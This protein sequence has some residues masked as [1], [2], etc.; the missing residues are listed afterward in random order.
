MTILW[1]FGSF[2]PVVVSCTKEIWQP[3]A[4]AFL[5]VVCIGGHWLEKAKKRFSR[6]SSWN[7]N[8]LHSA[9]EFKI[10]AS[11]WH[12]CHTCHTCLRRDQTTAS[13]VFFRLPRMCDI[14]FKKTCLTNCFWTIFLFRCLNI[15]NL[16]M[17]A[18]AM[19]LRV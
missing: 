19:V 5:V 16:L 17:C 15:P 7:A 1:L 4:R 10:G 12:T 6:Q 18:Y 11:N 14:K 9:S 3:W 13:H 2:F 8:W